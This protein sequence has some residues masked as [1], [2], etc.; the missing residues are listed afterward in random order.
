MDLRRMRLLLIVITSIVLALFFVAPLVMP[1][2]NVFGLSGTPLIIDFG[3]LWAD[4]DPLSATAYGIGDVLCHQ[5]CDRSFVINGS[6]MPVC[7]RDTFIVSGFLLGLLMSFVHRTELGMKRTAV[8]VLVAVV[9]IL[10]DHTV[11]MVFG[12]NVPFTRAVTGAVFGMAI[13]LAVECWFQYY[14]LDSHAQVY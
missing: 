1:Y 6:Q 5:Q 12:L 13:S 7:V 9:L 3:H 4:L 2:G 8:V 10:A 11:Q 14:E